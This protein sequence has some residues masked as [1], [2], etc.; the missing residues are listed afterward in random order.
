M[1]TR[2]ATA[3]CVLT[4]AGLLLAATLAPQEPPHY[5]LTQ[6]MCMDLGSAG[7]PVPRAE[8]RPQVVPR[9]AIVEV[10]LP[11]SPSRWSVTDVPAML[12]GTDAPELLPSPGRVPG[13]SDVWV[14]RFRARTS[15]AGTLVLREEPRLLTRAGTFRFPLTVK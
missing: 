4:G 7:V 5:V 15:G 12:T 8:C 10:Q 14:F 2:R 11:G 6:A 13:A 9:G 1:S 3:F